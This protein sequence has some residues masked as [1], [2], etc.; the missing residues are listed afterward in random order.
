M[1]AASNSTV[2]RSVLG[3]R[4]RRFCRLVSFACFGLTSFLVLAESRVLFASQRQQKQAPLINLGK[5]QSIPKQY[6]VV[7]R[8]RT[9]Q[10]SI[11]S[12][13]K[14]VQRLG[15]TIRFRY[16]SALLGFS[17]LLPDKAL[18][19]V[20]IV[21]EVE[22]I[23][24][25]LMVSISST[26]RKPPK[27][28][29]RTSERV[30]PLNNTY[31]YTETGAGVHVYVIDSGILI[32][33]PE[34]GGRASWAFTAIDRVADDCNG[35]GTHVAGTIG[36]STYGIAKE[37]ILH[38]VRVLRC[39]GIGPS[40]GV[41]AGIDWVTSHWIPPAVANL[42]INYPPDIPSPSAERAINNSI[43]SGVTYAIAAG[44]SD[45]DACGVTPANVLAAITVGSI[46]PTNDRRADESNFG[47]CLDLFAPGVDILSAWIND[48][49]IAP[50]CIMESV[51]PGHMSARCSGTSMAAPHVAGVAALYLQHHWKARPSEVWHYIHTYTN[52]VTGTPRWR[53]VID[54]GRGS[55]NELLHWGPLRGGIDDR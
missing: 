16:R 17:A 1:R 5:P 32:T 45:V 33:H 25:N 35:H 54:G 46:D 19:F 55:P 28:L 14:T 50:P 40:D 22:W 9:S 53:G 39:E 6:I 41:V 2:R 27:G 48:S 43:A 37:V 3:K 12:I 44:N 31:N 7:F 29:D 38:A 4:C 18:Q 15:G 52:N 13:E 42:S 10:N 23:E 30:L 24:A 51:T 21:R 8:P 34:F 36:G 26:Q 47:A 49:R 11:Q 20:R